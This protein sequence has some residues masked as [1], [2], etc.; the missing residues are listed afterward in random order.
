MKKIIVNSSNDN[1]N[2][3]SVIKKSRAIVINEKG[4]I[5]V[6]NMNGSYILPG[7]T[8]ENN[9]SPIITLRREINEE[10][11]IDIDNPSEIAEFY[12]YHNDFPKYKKEGYEKRLNIVFYYLVHINSN[13]IKES[14][15]TDYEKSQNSVIEEYS[16]S[17]LFNMLDIPSNNKWK[18][19][20]DKEL[21][22]IL[23]YILSQ[24]I[25]SEFKTTLGY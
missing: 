16:L 12:Y 14:K 5:Y 10:L 9:E 6:C 15:F 22:S 11:G 18:V 25:V 21:K 17:D 24:E 1:N 2:F 8:V 19:F 7:G 13:D 3:D 20:T 23:E 4:N